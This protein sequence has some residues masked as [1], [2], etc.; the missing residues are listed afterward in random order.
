MDDPLSAVD[1]HVGKHI[2][3]KVIGSHGLLRHKVKFSLHFQR[4]KSFVCAE[5]LISYRW[6]F[7][8][9]LQPCER[10]Y[11]KKPENEVLRFRSLCL[12]LRSRW[13]PFFLTGASAGDERDHVPAQGGW[14]PGAQ[15]RG[16]GGAGQLWGAAG[17]RG[18]LRRVPADLPSGGRSRWF[19]EFVFQFW[20]TC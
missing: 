8:L 9:F 12:N 1:S 4:K 14:D 7:V 18:R 20:V 3:D 17:A 10:R 13:V 15:G 2:F 11:F 19:R 16:G 6:R 5:V